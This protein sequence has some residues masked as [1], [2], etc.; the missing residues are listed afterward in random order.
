M[1]SRPA[2]AEGDGVVDPTYDVLQRNYVALDKDARAWITALADQSIKAS[3]SFHSKGHRTQRRYEIL[4]GLVL[5]AANGGADDDL[6]RSLLEQVIGDVAQFPSVPP[7]QLVGSLSAQEAARFADLCTQFVD[8]AFL[9]TFAED[10]TA[11]LR[12]AA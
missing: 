12:A 11:H 2:P 6:L 3:V 7:G 9:L 10:G 1:R 4:R 5:L 8:G